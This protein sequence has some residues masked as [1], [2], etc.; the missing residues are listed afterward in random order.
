MENARRRRCVQVLM[1]VP[2]ISDL[3]H[4]G[5]ERMCMLPQVMIWPA[6]L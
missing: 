1:L 2:A 5:A 4:M 3:Q 6:S